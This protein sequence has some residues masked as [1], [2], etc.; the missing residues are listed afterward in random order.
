MDFDI[1]AWAHHLL[2]T[3]EKNARKHGR[4]LEIDEAYVVNLWEQQDGLCAHT[5]WPM[6]PVY[7]HRGPNCPSLDRVDSKQ[8]Y[9]PGNVVLCLSWINRMKNDT[10]MPEWVLACAAVCQKNGMKV[11]DA[12]SV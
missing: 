4:P 2:N 5:G 10:P 8:G 3:A 12:A 6:S 1:A 11:T 7:E 9:V